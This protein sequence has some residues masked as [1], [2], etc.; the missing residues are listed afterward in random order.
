MSMI[1]DSAEL[2][3]SGE[4]SKK[5]DTFSTGAFIGDAPENVDT[6]PEESVKAAVDTQIGSRTYSLAAEKAA[7][8]EMTPPLMVQSLPEEIKTMTHV[9]F[10]PGMHEELECSSISETTQAEHTLILSSMQPVKKDLLQQNPLFTKSQLLIPSSL[11]QSDRPQNMDISLKPL[12]TSQEILSLDPQNKDQGLFSLHSSINIT[13]VGL[14]KSDKGDQVAVLVEDENPA[15]LEIKEEKRPEDR[16]L[17]TV[18]KSD[19]THKISHI[20]DFQKKSATL[21][22][23]N[24]KTLSNFCRYGSQSALDTIPPSGKSGKSVLKQ[25][26]W[27]QSGTVKSSK[28]K[29]GEKLPGRDFPSS[30]QQQQKAEDLSISTKLMESMSRFSKLLNRK[31]SKEKGEGDRSTVA[32]PLPKGM[33]LGIG[34][35]S[36]H[37]RAPSEF[38]KLPILKKKK[39]IHIPLT[40]VEL[41]AVADTGSDRLAAYKTYSFLSEI[42]RGRFSVVRQCQDDQSKQLFAAKIIPYK[43]EQQ[44]QV[45][46]EYQ[47]LKKLDHTHIVQ[48][49]AAFITPC[50]LVLIEE[51]CAG[52]ELLHNLAERDLYAEMH[53]AELL[54][55]ILSGVDYLHSSY[56]VHLDLKSDNILV[57]DHNLLKIVDLGSAQ[58]FTP[59][60]TLSVEHIQETKENKVNIALPKAPEVLEREAVGPETDIWAIGVLVFIM[61]SGDDPF[62]SELHWESEDNIRKGKIQFSRC[63]PGL[64]EGSVSFIKRTLNYKPW[65]RPS[66]AECLQI[67]WVKGL[68]HSSRH[69]HSIVCFSTDKLQAYLGEQETKREKACTKMDVPLLS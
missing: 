29:G 25:F 21:Q 46:H 58:T 44:Q 15:L 54:Q 23:S 27:R 64:S 41:A 45:L 12:E 49:H 4:K 30:L 5:V 65:G 69:C 37:K 51:L 48:L 13:N 32:S 7:M 8:I 39:D 24:K 59:G 66:A 36:S 38:Y 26:F 61:L 22:V 50:Y 52:R 33:L 67:P 14:K 28:Q 55:Q 31:Y 2:R 16:K 34:D 43:Q 19:S 57:T 63:Y 3:E 42:N 9:I 1:P 60:Q 53:V 17:S 18:E 10:A 20:N 11:E 62:K 6:D 40:P 35:A 47:L 68:H 56:I